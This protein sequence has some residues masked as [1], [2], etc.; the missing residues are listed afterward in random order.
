MAKGA[1]EEDMYVVEKIL[2]KRFS[3]AGKH[4]L[5]IFRKGLISGKMGRVEC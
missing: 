1:V 5:F 3:K 2:D 4:L